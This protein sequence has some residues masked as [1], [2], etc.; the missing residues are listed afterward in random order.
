[1]DIPDPCDAAD[2][3]LWRTRLGK[4]LGDSGAD[5]DDG[6]LGHADRLLELLDQRDAGSVKYAVDIDGSKGIYIGDHGNQTNHF[7]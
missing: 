3:E 4:A 2:Q 1:M 6:V 7:S 5:E